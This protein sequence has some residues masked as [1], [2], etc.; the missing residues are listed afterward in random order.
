M[1]DEKL[2][3]MIN[4]FLDGELPKAKENYL[5]TALGSDEEA[6][7]YFKKMN[8][9]KMVVSDSAEDFPSSLEESIFSELKTTNK[10]TA[11]TFFA[12]NRVSLFAYA[13][14]VL[15]FVMSY[16]FYDQYNYQKAQLEIAQKQMNQQE[17]LIE[18]IMNN[19]LPPVTVEP[20]SG[21]EIIIQATL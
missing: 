6:R 4:E 9:I 15:I 2:E 10:K 1:N 3:I 5:F 18:F 11:Y 21:N 19:Q 12:K 17:Q 16:F 20:D 14:T 8:S 7:E 13:L